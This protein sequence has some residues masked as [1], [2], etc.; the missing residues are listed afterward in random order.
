MA[1]PIAA[2]PPQGR[3]A[4]RACWSP[5]GDVGIGALRAVGPCG[6]RGRRGLGKPGCQCDR[7]RQ[8][9]VPIELHLCALVI[10]TS[11]HV[12]VQRRRPAQAFN[13][14]S[15]PQDCRRRS[16]WTASTEIASGNIPS[17]SSNTDSTE[18]PFRFLV[19]FA[20]LA[21]R[22]IDVLHRTLSTSPIDRPSSPPVMAQR[23][24]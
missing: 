8:L 1:V 15:R 13:R 7:R 3:A 4:I 2:P 19:Y 5:L 6:R 14:R 9:K 12:A 21:T 16:L 11:G 17:T 20:P 18:A 22:S 10:A 23:H 24:H